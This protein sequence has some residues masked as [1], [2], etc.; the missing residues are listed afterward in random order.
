M[1]LSVVMIGI[2]DIISFTQTK[3][4]IVFLISLVVLMGSLLFFSLKITF[5]IKKIEMHYK[6]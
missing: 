5:G 2:I 4:I 1:G 6:S 3:S